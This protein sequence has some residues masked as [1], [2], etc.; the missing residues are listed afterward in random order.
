M[1]WNGSNG[2]NIKRIQTK[3]KSGLNIKLISL[4]TVITLALGG[5]I[6]TLC[7]NSG[8]E[9]AEMAISKQTTSKISINK[10]KKRPVKSKVSHSPKIEKEKPRVVVRRGMYTNMYG[11]VMNRPSTAIV[12]TNKIDDAEKPIEE[13]VFRH[14]SDQK[15]A[16]LLLMEPGEMMIG[17]ASSLF[18]KNFAKSFLR[19]LKAPIEIL[20]EDDEFTTEL[21]MA[22]RDTRQELKSRLDAGEDIGALL[23]DEQKKLQ[24][25]GLFKVELKSEIEKI[26]RSEDLTE[27]EMNDFINAANK[28]LESRGGTPLSMPRFAARRFQIIRERNSTIQGD[29]K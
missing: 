11:Y 2:N 18:G 12:I 25:L 8:N 26:A 10:P 29:K 15:I 20:P 9:V 5:V 17:D 14:S 21:K 22:V 24:E 27:D 16:G 19:S 13:R 3:K 4:I 28:M 6:Y 1:P 7:L 23:L